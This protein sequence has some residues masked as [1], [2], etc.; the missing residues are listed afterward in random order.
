MKTNI[1]I[2]LSLFLLSAC[3]MRKDDP[4]AHAQSSSPSTSLAS[5]AIEPKDWNVESITK[6]NTHITTRTLKAEKLDFVMRNFRQPSLSPITVPESNGFEVYEIKGYA[7][8]EQ[9]AY[10]HPKIYINTGTAQGSILGYK[11]GVKGPAGEDLIEI[12]LPVALV[13][14][15][16]P[17]IPTAGGPSSG[18]GA[19]VSLP[20][21]YRIANE[22]ALETRVGKKV[23]TLPVCPKLFRLT[24]EDKEYWA[25]SPFDRE[26]P[27]NEFFRIKFRA[28]ASEMKRMLE[29]SAVADEAVNLITELS[30]SMGVQKKTVQ[31]EIPAD[32]FKKVIEQKLKD[33]SRV[34]ENSKDT[35]FMS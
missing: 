7:E 27:L 2:V 32:E 13:N 26:C 28:A 12:S 17:S 10:I 29:V 19:A 5:L 20:E 6:N 22:A 14:G 4:T 16:V 18:V 21:K 31:F 35:S 11:V 34:S 1:P 30:F 15:L 25:K 8:L 24:F 33:T 9:A 3:G 23:S